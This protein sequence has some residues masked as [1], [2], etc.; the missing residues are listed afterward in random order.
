MDKGGLLA[1]AFV[2]QTL[3]SAKPKLFTLAIV[4]EQ[5]KKRILL[6]RKKKGFGEGYF[7]GF[8][9]KVEPGETVLQAAH[10]ELHEEAGITTPQL[11][12]RGVLTFVFDDQPQPWE[13]HVFGATEFSG[14]PLETDE[15]APVWVPVTE[16]PYD[17]MWADD[18]Y[19]YPL[20][21]QG[22]C[23]EG[24]F[25]FTNTHTMVWHKLRE[26]QDT[27]QRAPAE[28]LYNV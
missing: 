2:Q 20:F 15:M 3:A 28:T 10:R 17:R 8:G 24:I 18:L 13:V 16:I 1:P 11:H 7:N 19:W 23:F 6:G 22:S 9:G 4:H 25:A 26:L 5:Q 27:K 12:H 14:E 21:L